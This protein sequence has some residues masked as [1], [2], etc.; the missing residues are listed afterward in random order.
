[1][2][3]TLVWFRYDLRLED[4]P[5]LA[6][7][8]TR[9]EVIPVF[10]WS[11]FEER[12]W[13]PGHNSRIWLRHSLEALQASFQAQKSRLILRTGSSLK[14]LLALV[15][16]TQ[17]D[18][19]FWNRRYEPA[20]IERDQKV[21]EAFQNVCEVKT[22]NASLLVEPGEVMTRDGKPFQVFT[23]FWK[24]ALKLA[25]F[26]PLA[27]KPS[28][29]S[30]SKWPHS[31]D[32]DQLALPYEKLPSWEVGEAAAHRLLKTFVQKKLSDY[33]T[34]RDYPFLDGVSNLSPHLHFGEISPRQVW[35]GVSEQEGGASFVRQLFWRE[36][37][38]H[39]LVYFPQTPLEALRPA[40]NQFPWIDS[41]TS[42]QA[43]QKGLTGYPFVDAGMRQ[44]IQTGTMHNRVRL[45]VAS[46][47][48]KDLLI[49]WQEGARWFWEWLVDADLANNTLGWQWTAG[50][51]A[52][53]APYFRIFNPVSQ[54]MKF[55]PE[56]LYI[57]RYVPELSRL[58]SE[59]IHAPWM[60]SDA[61][62]KEAGVELGKTYPNPIIDHVFA[63]ER[64][65]KA[66]EKIKKVRHENSY[67]RQ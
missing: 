35:K 10:I 34:R 43:W 26:D 29:Q 30:P 55:D 47:L 15:K 40:F 49:P 46:F 53:A 19:L 62:L 38:Y 37:A 17:A 48:T 27:K 54:G 63:R 57:K 3:R 20:S 31:L 7:A 65:L 59:W 52:D 28:L 45:V 39:L 21:R 32:L 25:P 56:G 58:S 13:M 42:L 5:A 18:A 8:S 44:L 66:F 23:P 22:F 2:Q 33:A 50:C 61:V 41:P 9:G 11:P 51:G 36:F 60:A 1:M 16:E 12:E 64:A 14:E 4:N 24:T 67:H 6:E